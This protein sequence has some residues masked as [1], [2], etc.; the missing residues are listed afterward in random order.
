MCAEKTLFV[1]EV[2]KPGVTHLERS[3]PE[4]REVCISI[5]IPCRISNPLDEI[6][7]MGSDQQQ[8]DRSKEK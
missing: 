5:T 1:Q 7:E 2:A 3:W 8:D 4:H 6:H